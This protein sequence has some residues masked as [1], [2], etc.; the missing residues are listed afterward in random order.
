ML[1]RLIPCMYFTN[2]VFG[3]SGSGLRRYKYSAICFSTPIKKLHRKDTVNCKLHSQDY[4]VQ[5][6]KIPK[7]R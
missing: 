5:I 2:L 6:R 4:S 3:L 1:S 7:I